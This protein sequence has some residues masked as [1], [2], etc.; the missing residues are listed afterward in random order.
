M[1]KFNRVTRV[2]RNADNGN[3]NQVSAFDTGGSPFQQQGSNIFDQMK[4]NANPNSTTDNLKAPTMNDQGMPDSSQSIPQQEQQ[5][6]QSQPQQSQHQE[7][8][9]QQQRVSPLDKYTKKPDNDNSGMQSKSQQQ[10]PVHNQSKS[11]QQES[12]APSKTIFDTDLKGWEGAMKNVDLVAGIEP[13]NIQK[14]LAGDANLFMEIIQQ[15]ARTSMH[16]AA[17]M[18]LKASGSGFTTGQEAFSKTIPDMITSHKFDNLWQGDS[19]MNHESAQPMVQALTNQLRNQYPQATPQEI[20]T[21]VQQYFEDFSASIT[22]QKQQDSS[23]EPEVT[24]SDIASFF[25]HK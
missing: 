25:N 12:Q 3:G 5:Q 17:F 22:G 14:A 6:K 16:N 4:K 9:T 18:S 21:H 20:Q 7:G 13:E 2:L 11:Q 1:F 15:V 23:N 10:A 19:V 8:S 24:T